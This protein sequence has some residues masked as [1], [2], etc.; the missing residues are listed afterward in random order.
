M[1]DKK[2]PVFGLQARQGI[3][4]LLLGFP[5]QIDQKISTENNIEFAQI[6]HKRLVKQVA[7]LKSDIPAHLV[8]QN[9]AG[10]GFLEITGPKAKVNGAKGVFAIGGG[11]CFFQ[12]TAAD[13]HA[14]HLKIGLR[15]T[16]L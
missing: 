5:V 9:V 16:G 15:H 3:Q 2:Q 14:N 13:I 11:R 12:G 1:T 10:A 8:I 4:A 6:F 7:L